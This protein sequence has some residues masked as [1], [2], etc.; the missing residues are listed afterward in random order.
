MEA[1]Q[2]LSSS[3]GPPEELEKQWR[4][5]TGLSDTNER[6]LG[7]FQCSHHGDLLVS[8]GK[9]YLSTN[10]IVF[11]AAMGKTTTKVQE[12]KWCDF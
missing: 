5:A 9:I 8:Q 4:E 6:L 3:N 1:H 12:G 2:A 7:E 10:H 11:I